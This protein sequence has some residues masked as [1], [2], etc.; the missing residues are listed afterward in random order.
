MGNH[1]WIVPPCENDTTLRQ[2]WLK[3]VAPLPTTDLQYKERLAFADT[4]D[5]VDQY[6]IEPG[7]DTGDIEAAFAEQDQEKPKEFKDTSFGQSPIQ[8]VPCVFD[9][10]KGN[11]SDEFRPLMR[12]ALCQK[13]PTRLCDTPYES[14]KFYSMTSHMTFQHDACVYPSSRGYTYQQLVGGRQVCAARWWMTSALIDQT[15]ENPSGGRAFT[16]SERKIT[17]VQ[18]QPDTNGDL[19]ALPL[20]EQNKYTDHLVAAT[21]K[22]VIDKKSAHML[23]RDEYPEVV[24]AEKAA[25][26]DHKYHVPHI[27][28]DIMVEWSRKLIENH[29]AKF[30]QMDPLSSPLELSPICSERTPIIWF[31]P[32]DM[33]MFLR[34]SDDGL[35]EAWRKATT[36]LCCTIHILREACE[37][38]DFRQTSFGSTYMALLGCAQVMKIATPWTEPTERQGLIMKRSQEGLY[39]TQAEYNFYL[40]QWENMRSRSEVIQGPENSVMTYSN[41]DIV[42]LSTDCRALTKKTCG[43][44]ID[45]DQQS[46]IADLMIDVGNTKATKIAGVVERKEEYLK[47]WVDTYNMY[48]EKCNQP[49]NI[50]KILKDRLQKSWDSWPSKVWKMTNEGVQLVREHIALTRV[51]RCTG[52]LKGFWNTFR[53]KHLGTV[54]NRSS[55]MMWRRSIILDFSQETYH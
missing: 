42:G 45:G 9:D 40:D 30:Y 1:L 33:K 15:K 31:T 18:G 3:A 22:P 10:D 13:D 20:V 46:L 16:W 11:I 36:L 43:I 19:A 49:N 47:T 5:K 2:W 29:S 38:T 51:D 24:H 50:K 6:S 21:V 37:F 17:R 34:P 7:G 26:S 14:K 35:E 41:N 48:Q 25:E 39:T 27:A 8:C 54:S 12:C 53:G 4:H 32:T 52:I 28:P 23:V 44:A 55:Q